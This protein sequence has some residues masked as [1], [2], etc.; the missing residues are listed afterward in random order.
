MSPAVK[1]RQCLIPRPGKALL[2]LALDDEEYDQAVGDF[3]EQY[4]LRAVEAG[5][6]KARA[7]FWRMLLR[8]YPHFI[9]DS[10][11]WRGVMIKTNLKIAWRVIKRQ[12]LFSVLNITGLGVSLACLLMILFHVKTELS[13][14]TGFPKADRIFR[15]QTDSQYGSTVRQWAASAPAMGPELGK[16]FP[17]IE[18]TARLVPTGPQVIVYR[19]AEGPPRR[20]EERGVFV[21]DASFLSMFDL[22]FVKGSRES[23]LKDPSSA[24]L[25]ASFA[26]K[27]FGDEDP[28]GKTL[29][30]E[31][32]DGPLQVTGVI[33]DIPGKTHL[34]IDALIS[35]PTFVLWAGYGPE[36]LNHRTWKALYT[37]VLLRP[38]QG[39]ASLDA[40]AAAFMKNFHVEQPT[41]VESIRFQPIRRI[42]LHSKLEGEIAPNSDITYV[43]VFTGAAL[44]IL[45]IAVVNFVNL[46]TAQSF[47]RIKEIG[48][49]KVIGARR[50]QLV[51]Q[52]LGEAGLLTGISA[53][54]AVVL[55]K[56]SIPFYSR[57]SGAAISFRDV[58]TPGN[59]VSLFVLLV[60]LTLLAGLYPAFFAS[61]FQPIGTLKSHRTPRSPAALLRKGL[62]V[63]QFVVSIFLIFSTITMSRQLDFFHRADLGFEKNNVIA[64][65]LYGD[66]SEKL[67]SGA[68]SL[69]AEMLRHSGVAGVALTSNLFGI[70]FSNE[71]LTPVGTPDK[72][73][74]PMLRFL[75][76]DENFIRTVGLKVVLGRDFEAGSDQKFAYIIS[77]STA[78]AL[79]LEQPLGVECLSDI[80]QGRAPIIGVIKDFHF[81]CLHSPIE[82]LV[83]EYLPAA[84]HYLL[85]KAR[86]GHVPEV[87]AY[88]KL[89]AGEISPDFLFTYS[90]VDEVF[91]RSYRTEDES[92]DLFKVF[93]GV[94]LFVACLGLFGLSVYAAE[95]RIKEIGIRKTLGASAPSIC[96]LLSGSFLRWV[97]AA[98]AVALPMAY[99]AMRKW[100]QNFAFHT[101]INAGTFAIAGF[102]VLFFAMITVGYQ[103]LKS[104]R[105]DPVESLRY[106]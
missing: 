21:A 43:F 44:L 54:L 3:E 30:V 55:L 6:A 34:K 41:R 81:A 71:R 70:P 57:Q 50:G 77:E 93:S 67:V 61:S 16:A 105:E 100:L 102:L 69:K 59:V 104:A 51:R 13:Y 85:V 9:W 46:A 7:G 48:V 101:R 45:L 92:Y 49:R 72:N 83:L 94:A 53:A 39:P 23:A 2:W 29:M 31:T 75:R 38:G 22:D 80:H 37:F 27:Y 1:E 19:P 25:T 78:A 40:R 52:Y 88:L 15:V 89:K 84:A 10:L 96:M 86:D 95:R 32:R 26:K 18:A 33:Q 68:E 36:I 63:F 66:F 87:L 82:P 17:E 35:M 60:L 11:Y 65:N 4:R 56:F 91:D 62:V 97:I 24:V 5:A 90:F 74:L 47:K 103:A 98:N 99:L 8:S 79:G 106:E 14:E 12:K 76:V 64:V 20:F 42:H 28:V 73:A 58:V